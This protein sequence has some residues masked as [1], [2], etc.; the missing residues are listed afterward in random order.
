MEK[1][2][3]PNEDRGRMFTLGGPASPAVFWCL[4]AAL[5]LAAY[6]ICL[7]FLFPGYFAPL[8]PFHI[9]FYEYV[10]ASYKGLSELLLHYPRPAAY[11]AM[12]LLGSSGISGLMAA[13]VLISLA[14]V[15]LTIRLFGFVTDATPRVLP[16]SAAAYLILLF[17]HPD[18]YFEHRHDFPAEVSYL[19]LVL[20][21]LAW[22]AWV[23]E[24]LS[25]GRI[26]AN[27]VVRASLLAAAL[28]FVVLFAFAKE[29]YFASALLIVF[30]LA[31]ADPPRRRW[32]F[33]F[34]AFIAVCEIA[35][36]IWT[37]HFN[38]PFV[39]I[40]AG[41]ANPYHVSLNP[42]SLMQTGWFYLAHLFN[43]A[44]LLLCLAV[45]W[46][47]AKRRVW[48]ITSIG[49]MLAGLAA[50]APHAMLPNHRYE[51]YAW[52]AAP[53]LLAPILLLDQPLGGRRFTGIRLGILA[54]VTVLAI[55][56]PGGYRS[57]YNS[58]TLQWMVRQ[59]QKSAAIQRSLSFL[60]GVPRPSRIL[61]VGLE[62]PV[63]PWQNTDFV[64][65][66]FGT[67][68]H[69][70]VLV[71]PAAQLRHNSRWVSFAEPNEV[72][73]A[74][75]DYVATY[76]T[77]GNMAAFRD[78]HPLLSGPPDDVMVPALAPLKSDAAAHPT[79]YGRLLRCAA[80]AIDWGLW[81]EAGQ[82]LEQA[83]ATGAGGDATFARL[84]TALRKRPA[85]VS[86]ASVSFG[87]RPAR[88]VQPDGSGLGVTELYWSVPDGFLV[89]VHVSSPDGPLFVS[90][91]KSG[92]E[93][94]QKWVT[95]GMRFYLQDVRGGKP[96]TA[97][98]TLAS[99]SIE[100]T[101]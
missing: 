80:T 73:L 56:G 19:F 92:H 100:V 11:A 38:G 78:V 29:T 24:P 57:E 90:S 21:L 54:V 59:E 71:Q 98:H 26:W 46:I 89:E 34:S 83:R 61:V 39:N 4:T 2:T 64:R 101:Q 81:T 79:D 87:A 14:N 76:Q 86:A 77:T 88:I 63:V 82:F 35:S 42:A 72:N 55:A 52:A 9:D 16:V 67:D 93:R 37:R 74:D 10:G 28:L 66:M 65:L 40:E 36:L 70:T 5:A 53:L 15:V 48:M 23:R 43:P 97:A 99:V 7:R 51:E 85:P 69:W 20:S 41:A 13:G 1:L 25:S 50:L 44:L 31:L 8:S 33:A 47:S 60:A 12:K 94:T 6:W 30:A 49:W 22:I 32:H 58:G 27:P 3:S 96:L 91:D 84:S 17:A 62:D 95:N 18:F 75:Y 45:L 68:I